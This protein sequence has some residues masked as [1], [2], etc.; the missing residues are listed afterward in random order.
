MYLGFNKTGEAFI[1]V[2]DGSAKLAE[3][4]GKLSEGLGKLGSNGGT[5]ADGVDKLADGTGELATNLRTM[6][7]KGTQLTTASGKVAEGTAGLAKGLGA[8]TEKTASMP[9]DV[10]KLADGVEGYVSGTKGLIDQVQ[11]LGAL[12]DKTA[13]AG[14]LTQATG[15]LVTGLESYQ[16]RMTTLAAGTNPATGQSMPCPDDVRTQFGD[17]GCAGYLAGL[18]QAGTMAAQG[19][20]GQNGQPGLI[21]AARSVDAGVNGLV[22]TLA[23]LP[24]PS[25]DQA[26]KLPQLKAAGDKLVEGT[27]GLA[28]N[29]PQ[30]T[31]GIASAADGASKLAEGAG[32]LNEGVTAYTGGVAKVA[33]NV[34]TMADGTTKL[35]GGVRDY[36]GGVAKVADGASQLDTGISKLADGL[37]ENAGSLPNYDETKRDALARAASSPLEVQ[38]MDAF[39]VPETAWASLLVILGLWLGAMATFLMVR[40]IRSDLVLE[41][42]ATPRILLRALL[43]GTGI[44]LAQALAFTLLSA[45]LL[46]LDFGQGASL[47]GV[48]AVAG[49]AFAAVNQALAAWFGGL[50]RFLAIALGATVAVGALTHAAPGV[51]DAVRG[52]TPLAPAL[53]GVRAALTGGSVTGAVVLLVGWFV[54]G[55]AA[56]GAAVAKARRVKAP[57]VMRLVEA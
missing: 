21:Q 37:A 45:G 43:P 19:L 47:F 31:G 48:L 6:A 22:D 51:F 8:M 56:I 3:G 26:Q 42:R 17:A 53:D 2:R 54:L 39:K 57:D 11:Q 23:T 15:G 10:S 28:D 9:A 14:K 49:V 4:S 18:K 38:G 35:A 13:D 30:L 32:K 7:D 36:T 44:A 5:L 25:P 55:A 40:P 29:L 34:G 27:R 46:G 50:G 20:D 12:A 52:W 16:K 1:G 41:T 24:K 33:D